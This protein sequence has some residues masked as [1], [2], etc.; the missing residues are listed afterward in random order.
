MKGY[1]A[2]EAAKESGQG[3]LRQPV[4]SPG[5]VLQ[6]AAHGDTG[7]AFMIARLDASAHHRLNSTVAVR[8][9]RNDKVECSIHS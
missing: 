4:S 6:G 3:E 2:Q 1:P 9:T 5:A 7:W 8:V